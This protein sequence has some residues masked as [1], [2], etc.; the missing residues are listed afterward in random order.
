VRVGD[1]VGA[2]IVEIEIADEGPGI[3]PDVL[4]RLGSPFVTTK[5]KGSG[6]GLFLARRLT[7]SAGGELSIKRGDPRGSVCIVRLP[8][9]K[10]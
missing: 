5:A 9:V 2:G 7:Q 1:R 3:P 10:E 4:Q 8:R 6:L